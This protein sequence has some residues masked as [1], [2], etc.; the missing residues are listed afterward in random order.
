MN[1]CRFRHS[2]VALL[3]GTSLAL[4]GCGGSSFVNPAF[5][6]TLF[7]GVVPV[8]PGPNA[9]FVLAIG[10]N[11]TDQNVEFVITVERSVLQLDDTGVPQVNESG[12]FITTPE[13][14]TVRLF[15]LPTGGA[16][17]I[18]TLFDC[19]ESPVT[20]IGLG[21]NLLPTDRHVS[22]GGGGSTGAPGTG[23]TVPNLN[24]LQLSDGN[25][26]CGDTVLF[27]A[28]EDNSVA[29]NVSVSVFLLPG[30]EQPS[31]FSGPN[32][33]ANLAE[34]QAAQSRDEE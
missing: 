1:T 16:R 19:A 29:G 4:S 23:I 8:T 9:A 24:P 34:F 21:E 25:F 2:I 26:N 12:Q 13:R 32:T 31:V 28:F 14:E 27:Q 3:L 5:F 30:S 10:V 18:G 15:T 17:Q 11:E 20:L 7:G 22:V 6:N 33:F